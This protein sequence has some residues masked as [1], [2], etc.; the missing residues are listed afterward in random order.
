LNSGKDYLDELTEDVLVVQ[1]FLDVDLQWSA[2]SWGPRRALLHCVRRSVRPV[3][4]H[5]ETQKLNEPRAELKNAL[6]P[7]VL[8]SANVAA[9]GSWTSWL[10]QHYVTRFT[11]VSNI[12]GL[13]VSF[14]AIRGCSCAQTEI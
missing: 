13:S 6:V 8:H 2:K 1:I 14:I 4:L 3:L 11:L 12:Y 7:W 10:S 9:S 5:D